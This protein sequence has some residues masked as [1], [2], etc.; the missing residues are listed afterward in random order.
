MEHDDAIGVGTS[1]HRCVAHSTATERSARKL[2]ISW[3]RSLAA[4]RI[5]ADGRFVHQQH[6]R[7]VQQRA[8]QFDA[9][10]IAAAQL[11]GLVVRAFGKPEPRQLLRDALL[12]DRAR[13]AVQAGVKQ[14]IGGHR[15]FEIERRLLKDNA[16]HRQRGHRIAPHVVPHDPDAAGIGHE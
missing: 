10:A 4:R 12:G 5:E 1:S 11:R 9:A 3:R 6:A 16:E 15:E 13:N 2:S 8:R 14:Q 7:F